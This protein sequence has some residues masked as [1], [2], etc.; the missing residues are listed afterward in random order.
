MVGRHGDTI[1]IMKIL[2]CIG[3]ATVLLFG[4]LET[5]A[6]ES[7]RCGKWVIS[8]AMSLAELTAKCGQPTTRDST[9]EDVLVRNP[10]TGFMR[11]TGETTTETWIYD[12]GTRA[13]PM[14]VTIVD[15]KIKRI[16]RKPS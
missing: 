15:G 8:S 2:L 10:D 13:A 12:R 6:D 1:V 11:K 7:F 3:L 14:V 16:E 5:R 9:T 4:S